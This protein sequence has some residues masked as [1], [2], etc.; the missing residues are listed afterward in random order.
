MGCGDS[1]FKGF[2]SDVEISSYK[3]VLWRRKARDVLQYVRGEWLPVAVEYCH[4][5]HYS[6]QQVLIV[7][8]LTSLQFY[9]APFANIGHYSRAG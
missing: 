4:S 1:R 9:V 7:K 5:V 8:T 2:V 3:A 6:P